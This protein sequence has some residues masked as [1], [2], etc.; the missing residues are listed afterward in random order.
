MVEPSDA[1]REQRAGAALG[2]V[3]VVLVG[4]THPGNIGA[5]ARAMKTMGLSRLAL[6]APAGFPSAEATARASGADDLLAAA[7]VHADLAAAI[8]DCRLVLATSARERSIAWPALGPRPAAERLLAAAAH[9]DVALVFGREHSGLSNEELALA[10][11]M[12]QIPAAAAFSS[13]NLAAAVQVLAYELRLAAL[14]GAPAAPH[15]P[16]AAAEDLERLYAHWL[17]LMTAVGFLDPAKPKQLPRRLRRLLN[18]AALEASEVQILRG[19]LSAVGRALNR[20]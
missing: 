3:R 15:G 19:F 8:A 4:T 2:R 7:T 17:E 10:G 13:L 20:R 16:L 11:A 1:A 5:A 6:V 14:G 18:K 9:G 12:V